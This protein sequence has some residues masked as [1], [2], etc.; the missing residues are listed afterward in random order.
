MARNPWLMIDSQYQIK[1]RTILEPALSLPKDRL[2]TNLP[3]VT[4]EER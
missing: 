4:Q 3:K 2:K 1:R